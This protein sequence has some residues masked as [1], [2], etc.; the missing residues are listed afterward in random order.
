[1]RTRAPRRQQSGGLLTSGRWKKLRLQV[2]REEPLCRLR[3]DG[4]T[5][6][7][8]TADHIITVKDRPDL[9]YCRAN[10]RGSCQSCNRARGA[11]PLSAVRA[12]QELIRP[13]STKRAAA[14]EFF[15]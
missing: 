4:C 5:V 2:I 14:L 8:D 15:T 3:L 7:S 6:R 11:R 10:L 9:R 12:E 13:K 1:M